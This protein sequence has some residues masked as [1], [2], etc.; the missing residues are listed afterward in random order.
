MKS[1]VA[2]SGQEQKPAPTKVLSGED[3]MPLLYSV[4]VFKAQSLKHCTLAIFVFWQKMIC[5]INSKKV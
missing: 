3:W 1:G 5:E 2:P 4:N